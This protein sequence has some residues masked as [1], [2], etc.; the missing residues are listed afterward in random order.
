VQV[1][2]DETWVSFVNVQ[3]E[4]QSKQW[5]HT[6]SPNKPK[7]FK[8]T[9]ARKLMATVF[10]GRKGMLMVKFMQ[11]G[12]TIT[13]EM[14]SKTLNKLHT[15]IQNKRCGML[16]S[17]V[18]LLHDNEHPHTHRAACPGALLEHFNWELFDH[19][20]YDPHLA[21]SGYHLFTYLN[22]WLQPQPFNNNELMERVKTWLRSQVADFFDTGIQILFPDPSASIPAMTS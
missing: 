12:T 10:C 8:Q 15:A 19:P 21:P 13:S 14:Y 1:T 9:S 20:P 16:T 22:N 6:H 11:Q 7:K 2:D 5:I 18:V 3:T 17:G 4:E